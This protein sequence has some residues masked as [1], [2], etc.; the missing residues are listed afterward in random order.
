[1]I[2]PKTKKANW[3]IINYLDSYRAVTDEAATRERNLYG[4]NIVHKNLTASQAD[5][6]LL[7]Y[8]SMQPV[9]LSD[10]LM[11]DYEVTNEDAIDTF[12][13]IHVECRDGICRT[14]NV[15]RWNSRTVYI[16]VGTITYAAKKSTAQLIC[17]IEET[18]EDDTE[19]DAEYDN[20]SDSLETEISQTGE[21]VA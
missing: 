4:Y 10:L 5:E 7:Q 14:G 9:D 13:T 21:L 1:M 19:L 6:W 20:W 11:W 12:D 3:S 15:M 16:E 17:K 8:R 2:H 18:Y